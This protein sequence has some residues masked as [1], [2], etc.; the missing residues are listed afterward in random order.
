VNTQK[1]GENRQKGGGSIYGKGNEKLLFYISKHV[2]A[3]LSL[4]E[5][6]ISSTSYCEKDINKCDP[7]IKKEIKQ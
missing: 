7:S 4:F 5:Y 3:S 1:N 2:I 6:V